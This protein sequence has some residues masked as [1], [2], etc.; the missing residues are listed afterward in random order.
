MLI[1]PIR[2]VREAASSSVKRFLNH[3]EADIQITLVE[4]L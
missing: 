3:F 4:C 1:F 2:Y